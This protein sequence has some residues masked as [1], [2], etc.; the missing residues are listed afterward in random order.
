MFMNRRRNEYIR[1]LGGI[2]EKVWTGTLHIAVE[3]SH[4]PDDEQ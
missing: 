1:T 3:V 2:C 4:K